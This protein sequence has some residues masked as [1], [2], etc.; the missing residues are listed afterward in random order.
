[1]ANR[2]SAAQNRSMADSFP[3]RKSKRCS[4]SRSAQIVKLSRWETTA[5]LG[6]L[7]NTSCQL[8]SAQ[9]EGE[10]QQNIH[11]QASDVAP[12]PL[13]RMPRPWLVV[14]SDGDRWQR[15]RP[16]PCSTDVPI[17]FSVGEREVQLVWC[18]R[19]LA[20]VTSPIH[21]HNNPDHAHAYK[22]HD[23]PHDLV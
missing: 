4:L 7:Q 20:L 14:F 3:P 23:W 5:K 21:A 18:A 8:R 19:A 10:T 12:N 11:T 2:N 1:M 17:V 16:T 13:R 6:R 15:K 9:E 22:A